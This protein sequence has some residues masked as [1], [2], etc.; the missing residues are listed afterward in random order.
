MLEETLKNHDDWNALERRENLERACDLFRS[1]SFKPE[2]Y[3]IMLARHPALWH[4]T[5]SHLT[6]R[7]A[8]LAFFFTRAH[9]DR[10]LPRSPHVLTSSFDSFRYKF[11][12]VFA[13]M[14][15]EQREMSSTRLFDCELEFIRR[16]HLFLE[17]ALL[18]DRPNKKGITRVEN[19]K[20]AHILEPRLGE[21]LRIC[22]RDL[23][24]EDDYLVFC[25]YL[26]QEKF[27]NELLGSRIDS[28]LKKQIIADIRV[29][30][31]EEYED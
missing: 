23:L 24:T 3:S 29:Q 5:K 9:L 15:F 21:F 30:K 14:G 18:Y 8:D 16:R 22:T 31:R 7:F 11:N 20:L 6:T 19:P 10:L 1:F 26:S 28:L 2:I 4:V 17:R 13:L 12:Y 25:D 27:D